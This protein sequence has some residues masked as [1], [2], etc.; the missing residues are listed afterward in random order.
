MTKP[1]TTHSEE[2]TPA[3]KILLWYGNKC[4]MQNGKGSTTPGVDFQDAR[5]ELDILLQQ[6][7][8]KGRIDELRY[9][10]PTDLSGDLHISEIYERLA[11]LQKQYK[12]LAWNSTDLDVKRRLDQLSKEQNNE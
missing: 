7:E 8:L 6:A 2:I 3:E 4:A 11:T 9:M 10:M 5:K 1:N 12:E